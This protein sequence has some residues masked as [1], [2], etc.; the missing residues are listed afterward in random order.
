M[1]ALN[2][3]ILPCKFLSVVL[4]LCCSSIFQ[5]LV[6]LGYNNSPWKSKC[7]YYYCHAFQVFSKKLHRIIEIVLWFLFKHVDSY[8]VPLRY[9]FFWFWFWFCTQSTN[10]DIGDPKMLYKRTSFLEIHNLF[11]SF[12]L[13]FIHSVLCSQRLNM[14]CIMT[15]WLPLV[16]ITASTSWKSEKRKSA[17]WCVQ[18]SADLAR[19]ASIRSPALI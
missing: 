9:S 15:L 5:S 6:P 14:D 16:H 17:E 10:S 8:M 1:L 2:R 18:S 12:S 4:E 3:H 13:P 7:S 11:C 19:T